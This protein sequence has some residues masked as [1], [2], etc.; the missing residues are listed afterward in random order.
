MR[1][2]VIGSFSGHP[3]VDC[4]RAAITAFA[5]RSGPEHVAAAD[6]EAFDDFVLRYYDSALLRKSFS[7][8]WTQNWPINTSKLPKGATAAQR[9]LVGDPE[10]RKA[11]LSATK[12]V[13]GHLS[14]RCDFCGQPADERLARQR[15]PLLMG[16]EPVNFGARGVAGGLLACGQCRSSLMG[17]ALAPLC[18]GRILA[19]IADEPE[20][21]LA[22]ARVTVQQLRLRASLVDAAQEL[23][24]LRFPKSRV[25]DYLLSLDAE[26]LLIGGVTVYSFSNSGLGPSLDIYRLPLGVPTFLL[27]ARGIGTEH[28]WRAFL[29][30]AGSKTEQ[31]GA[32]ARRYE[33]LEL[34]FQLP[35]EVC[36]LVRQYLFP[37]CRYLAVDTDAQAALAKHQLWAFVTL[38]C[39]EVLMMDRDRLGAV[40]R[41]GDT[42]AELSS[43]DSHIPSRALRAD[44]YGSVRTL[45]LDAGRRWSDRLG[46]AVVTFEDAVLIFESGEGPSSTWR[47]AWDLALI[48]MLERM[49][50]KPE[51]L[52]AVAQEELAI[53]DESG[54]ADVA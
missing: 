29:R 10:V 34:F 45:L 12:T 32:D 50:E 6:L 52:E 23:P 26:D 38:L 31:L 8:L 35:L 21:T 11:V 48:R 13:D 22:I 33:P 7:V 39:E 9:R 20:A 2:S 17:L 16:E 25:V 28:A 41:L 47:L 40:Q 54:D 46:R 42:L 36:R 44:R 51:I 4:G 43:F 15:I 27:R 37:F 3:L 5:G 18:S 30:F 14:A 49:V 53:A 19:I 24:A 1:A